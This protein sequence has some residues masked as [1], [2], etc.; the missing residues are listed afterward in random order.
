M[1]KDLKP[2]SG[3]G[4]ALLAFIF[5]LAAIYLFISALEGYA[6]FLIIVAV[7]IGKGIMVLKPNHC[8][9]LTFFGSYV[10]TVKK[11]GLL[12]INPLYARQHISLR[13]ENF[14]SA[15]LKVND[16][17]GNP[18]EIAAVIVWQVS[19][20]YKAAFDVADF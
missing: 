12:F 6:V 17:M 4:A 5:F 18:I 10:G 3:F 19:D 1:E 14:E 15:K 11:N 20:T 9:V 8:S 2:L 13:S 7:F 16:K